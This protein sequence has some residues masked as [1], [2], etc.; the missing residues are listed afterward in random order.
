MVISSFPSTWPWV[1]RGAASGTWERVALDLIEVDRDSAHPCW[2]LCQS[3]KPCSSSNNEGNKRPYHQT[4][5]HP[6][7]D[8]WLPALLVRQT[9]WWLL[10]IQSDEVLSGL[11][12]HL[13]FPGGPSP[14]PCPGGLVLGAPGMVPSPDHCLGSLLAA[15]SSASPPP[16]SPSWSGSFK[17]CQSITKSGGDVT[18]SSPTPPPASLTLHPWL[19]LR[20]WHI[21]PE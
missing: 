9:I 1:F 4:V 2:P 5:E 16:S 21:L 3:Y 6:S 11:W 13:S 20:I 7:R 15:G 14:P 17:L 12:E 8:D 19:A 10:Y 18:L